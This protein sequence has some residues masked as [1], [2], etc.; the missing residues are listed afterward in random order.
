VLEKDNPETQAAEKK[1][2]S[3]F[4]AEARLSPA[5]VD[6]F[7]GGIRYS[8][9]GWLKRRILRSIARKAGVETRFDRN[10]DFTDWERVRRFARAFAE[11]LACAEESF[12]EFPRSFSASSRSSAAFFG[13]APAR[14]PTD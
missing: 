6:I 5:L 14:T 9:Y 3:D 13:G 4:L 8:E 2:V 1:I 12:R 7:P 11:T 10:Y